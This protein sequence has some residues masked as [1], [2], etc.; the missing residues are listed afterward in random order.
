M[1]AKTRC[2]NG[3]IVAVLVVSSIA[4]LAWLIA[5]AARFPAGDFAPPEIKYRWNDD[6]CQAEASFICR[7]A[8]GEFHH[9][10]EKRSWFGARE[11]CAALGMSLATLHSEAEA[12]RLM[13]THQPAGEH[14]D[15]W[16]GLH[17]RTRECS[18]NGGCFEWE[19]GSALV[20]TAWADGE[21]NDWRR[22]DNQR[23]HGPS[24]GQGGD[25]GHPGEDC[26]MAFACS[27]PMNRGCNADTRHI[28]DEESDAA[29]AAEAVRDERTTYRRLAVA[30]LAVGILGCGLA[31]MI[32]CLASVVSGQSL[33]E[34]S[35]AP[36]PLK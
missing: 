26:V 18:N 32:A 34:H 17:D 1:A 5:F 24:S 2:V 6:D 4:V 3:A 25:L 12:E 16:I 13:A 11:G 28:A 19:D 36:Q 10:A 15:I 35:A 21:P 23:N 33:L 22:S 7:D 31:A 29:L 20:W 27:N 9:V 30:M 8:A 14:G